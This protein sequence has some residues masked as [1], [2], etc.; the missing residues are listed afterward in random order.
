MVGFFLL[1][2]RWASSPIYKR[3]RFLRSYEQDGEWMDGLVGEDKVASWCKSMGRIFLV[4]WAYHSHYS[5]SYRHRNRTR[6]LRY[7]WTRSDHDC[8][9]FDLMFRRRV[10]L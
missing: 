5:L 9:G 4:L 6:N 10:L 2:S 7:L 3:K 8:F 1:F